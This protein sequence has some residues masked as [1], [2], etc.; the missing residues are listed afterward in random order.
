M[1]FFSQTLFNFKTFSN[2]IDLLKAFRE[3]EN[4]NLLS[5][6]FFPISVDLLDLGLFYENRKRIIKHFKKNV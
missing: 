6:Y 2:S 1:F 5:L 4:L 3:H